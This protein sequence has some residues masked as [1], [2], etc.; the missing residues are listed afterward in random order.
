[1]GLFQASVSQQQRN[2]DQ[3]VRLVQ[4][5][6]GAGN[7]AVVDEVCATTYVEHQANVQPPNR[8]GVKALIRMLRQAMPD[9]K[10]VVEDSAAEGDMVWARIRGQGTHQG[11]FMGMA[12]TGK[13][14]DFILIDIARFEQGKI[15]EHWGYTDRLATLE[16]L[17]A[18]P[19]PA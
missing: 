17:G 4:E 10:V 18:I 15:A 11:P 2:K 13:R 1:M 7:L 16:Q 9:L 12:P 6:F 19:R 14:L 3:L 8:E 5:G